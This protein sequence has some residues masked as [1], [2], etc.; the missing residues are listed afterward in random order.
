VSSAATAM[1]N[2]IITEERNI[3]WGSRI[4]DL[5]WRRS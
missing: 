4:S 2:A 3:A 1:A 5:D